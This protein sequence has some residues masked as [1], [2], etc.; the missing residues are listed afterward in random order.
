MSKPAIKS[1][2][3]L[4]FGAALIAG[5]VDL[6]LHYTG[7]VEL[8]PELLGA[9]WTA[10][11]SG[12]TGIMLR[13][14]TAVPLTR[15]KRQPGSTG[16]LLLLLSLLM[17]GSCGGAWQA[18][19]E[20]AGS[21]L[22]ECALGCAM[23]WAGEL[24][25]LLAPDSISASADDPP[26]TSSAPRE[27]PPLRS[28]GPVVLH[29]EGSDGSPVFVAGELAG[30]PKPLGQ[31]AWVG[32]FAPRGSGST[33][34]ALLSSEPWLYCLSSATLSDA[35]LEGASLAPVGYVPARPPRSRRELVERFGEPP[36]F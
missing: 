18:S 28:G 5:V 27:V 1:R 11:V 17:S 31:G 33:L 26:L 32:R 3:I 36:G 14:R 6:L 19:G 29:L 23:S 30:D 35:I 13:Y 21:C 7:A 24:P 4:T 10:V 9:G 2:T 34:L 22:A 16:L 15:T 12:V 20:R 25:A 8:S